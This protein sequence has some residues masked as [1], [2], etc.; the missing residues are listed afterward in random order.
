M[1]ARSGVLFWNVV[2][3]TDGVVGHE[4]WIDGNGEAKG[5]EAGNDSSWSDWLWS[6]MTVERVT[7]VGP[8]GQGH[9]QCQVVV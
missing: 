6:W 5:N 9:F 4:I 8:S 3:K 1:V 2:E 7:W